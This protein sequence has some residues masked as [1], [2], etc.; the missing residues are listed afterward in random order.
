MTIPSLKMALS[1]Q[2][3]PLKPKI[4]NVL[5]IQER[6]DSYLSVR[7][8]HHSASHP[9]LIWCPVLMPRTHFYRILSERGKPKMNLYSSL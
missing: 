6:V 9:L 5:E 3:N 7:M 2:Q 4:P 8:S 1:S